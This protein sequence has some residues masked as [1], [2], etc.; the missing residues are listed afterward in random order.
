MKFR[1]M[2]YKVAKKTA[3]TNEQQSTP[4]ITNLEAPQTLL[5]QL[6]VSAVMILQTPVATQMQ[7]I[8]RRFLY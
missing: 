2:W 7:N 1:A 3:V 5:D 8:S 4:K 6:K